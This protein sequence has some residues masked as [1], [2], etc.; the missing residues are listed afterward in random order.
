MK[1]RTILIV[2]DEEDQATAVKV[3]LER[4]GEFHV[5]IVATGYEALRHLGGEVPA[6]LL[7]AVTLPDLSVAELCRAIRSRERTSLMPVIVLGERATGIGSIDALDIGADDYLAK[8]LNVRELEARLR[9]ML[10]RGVREP[11]QAAERFR[12]VHLDADFAR[13]TVTVDNRVVRLTRREFLLLRFLVENRNRVVGREVL[14][15]HVWPSRGQHRRAVDSAIYKLRL[16]LS[17]AGRQIETVNGFGYQFTE[18]SRELERQEGR[19][20]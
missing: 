10:R 15:A 20:S 18:P 16:K 3:V 7:L 9:A 8:P 4:C 13:I 6:A 11:Q 5:D 12:G 1:T 17:R 19:M 14:L 2:D